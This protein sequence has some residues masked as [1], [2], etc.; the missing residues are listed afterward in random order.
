MNAILMK[1]SFRLFVQKNSSSALVVTLAE[2]DYKFY[3]QVF[4][5]VNYLFV[6]KI[7]KPNDPDIVSHDIKSINDQDLTVDTVIIDVSLSFFCLLKLF[8]VFKKIVNSNKNVSFLFLGCSSLGYNN[9]F[10]KNIIRKGS[11]LFNVLF[12]NML[13]LNVSGHYYSRYGIDFRKDGFVDILNK[14]GSGATTNVSETNRLKL[15]EM[16]LTN[17]NFMFIWP[18]YLLIGNNNNQQCV[19]YDIIKGPHSSTV[20]NVNANQITIDRYI[21]GNADVDLVMFSVNST[22]H[23]KYVARIPNDERGL[24]LCEKNH[25]L[26]TKYSTSEMGRYMPKPYIVY[27][28]ENKTI[29]VEERLSGYELISYRSQVEYISKQAIDLIDSF[30]LSHKKN[31]TNKDLLRKI[32]SILDF[33]D[34]G[35]SSEI[36]SGLEHLNEILINSLQNK[37][38]FTIPVHGDY[39]IGNLLLDKQQNISG[40][41][42]WDHFDEDGLLLYDHL[43]LVLYLLKSIK[44]EINAFD[45][46]YNYIL[47]WKVDAFIDDLVR[48]T[49]LSYNITE[50]EFLSYR[51]L[52]WLYNIKSRN[53]FKYTVDSEKHP[54]LSLESQLQLIFD[55]SKILYNK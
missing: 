50:K 21:M 2:S 31:I 4:N 13:G 11:A 7:E 34:I 17:R 41:I 49:M 26:L 10:K 54:V 36:Q 15:K 32:S 18:Y 46:Y 27:H 51:I 24:T 44:P 48:D 42:D 23:N 35:I 29:F 3:E 16:I 19:L 47:P 43:T 53:L 45:C 20:F 30:Q 38:Q 52:Y 6:N 40:V 33:S 22:M 5:E 9:F 14:D 39:K 1:N 25:S 8:P 28:Y 55:E 12:I 37:D